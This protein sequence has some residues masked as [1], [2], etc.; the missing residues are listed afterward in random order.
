M[1]TTAAQIEEAYPRSKGWAWKIVEVSNDLGIDPAWLA[2][3]IQSESRFNP[4]AVNKDSQAT[5][6][7][8][9]MPFTAKDLFKKRGQSVT[10]SQAQQMVYNMSA[11]QQ[12][13]LAK[14]YL[15]SKGTLRSQT[16]VVLAVFYP[17]A[18]GKGEGFDIADHYAYKNGKYPRGTS[19]YQRRYDY[20]VRINGGITYAGDYEKKL[21]KNWKIDPPKT[22][23]KKSNLKSAVKISTLLSLAYLLA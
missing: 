12:L 17:Y 4:Q 2:N 8:Q 9:F 20:L 6:L 16:D 21:S 14:E 18:I 5:G 19:E 22:A 23:P 3:I 15:A 1:A 10:N 7:I 11:E 13:E